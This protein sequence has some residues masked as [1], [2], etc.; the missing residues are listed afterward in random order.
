[1]NTVFKY[2]RD[3][4]IYKFKIRVRMKFVSVVIYNSAKSIVKSMI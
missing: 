1:M 4:S 3:N 2:P